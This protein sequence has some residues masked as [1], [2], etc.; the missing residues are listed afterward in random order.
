MEH[1][2]VCLKSGLSIHTLKDGNPSNPAVLLLHGWPS[3]AL[4]WRNIIP[5]LAD[6]FYVLAPDLPGHGRSDKPA[7]A[8]YS[9]NFFRRFIRE[10]M[11]AT[12][13][14]TCRLVC[15]DLGGMAGLSFGVHHPESLE[16]LVVMNT[17]PYP[18]WHWQLNLFIS[19]LKQPVLTPFFLNPV[20][21]KQVLANGF[22]NRTN[23]T[24]ELVR[25]FRQPW[26]K[27]GRRA[28]SRTI[29]VPAQEMVE[30]VSALRALDLPCLVLWGKRDRFFPFKVARRL[31]R[32]L[33][34]AR[35][36]GIDDAGHF[37]QEEQP[38]AITRALLAF[39]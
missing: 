4:L 17:G 15:H 8:V 13:Q 33:P 24:P 12:G 35:L 34:D 29:D 36:V 22:H 30:P 20:L 1:E 6:K 18:D 7:R 3:S 27:D 39:L 9:L 10:F 28:F 16:K 11:A 2:T 23:L 19:L 32:D 26:L 38:D 21:F 37:L 31:Q 14:D 5:G 25:M